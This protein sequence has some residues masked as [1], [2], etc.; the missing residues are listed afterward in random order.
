MRIGDVEGVSPAGDLTVAE[1][2][3][4]AVTWVDSDPDDDA[5]VRVGVNLDADAC[6]W[7]DGDITW[8]SGEISE[9][10]DGFGGTCV[11][12]TSGFASGRYRVWAGR[13]KTSSH[14][15]RSG[16]KSF[17]IVVKRQRKPTIS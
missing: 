16:S 7:L 12:D 15:W 8:V 2:S 17:N 4:V 5:T 1:G 10:A 11:W 13:S 9:D 14:L 6:P 3:G